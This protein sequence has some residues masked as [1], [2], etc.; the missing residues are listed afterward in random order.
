MI[1][2]SVVSERLKVRASLAKQGLRELLAKGTGLFQEV[3]LQVLC[4]IEYPF[5]LIFYRAPSLNSIKLR[6]NKVRCTSWWSACLY[7]EHEGWWICDCWIN[8]F[9]GNCLYLDNWLLCDSVTCLW[10]N[11]NVIFNSFPSFWKESR[12]GC[13]EEGD[14]WW[15]FY[16]FCFWHC[17][18]STGQI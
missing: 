9:S 18:H 14:G 3:T 10:I 12:I 15:S 16:I 13:A 11:F 2:P 7:K 17:E 4:F 6:F 1:T 5:C 8:Q